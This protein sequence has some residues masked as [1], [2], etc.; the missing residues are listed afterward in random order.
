MQRV[1]RAATAA[2]RFR[3]S[4]K[5]EKGVEGGVGARLPTRRA[6]SQG[7]LAGPC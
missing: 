5:G 6:E 1:L 3:P 7:Q 4:E 2:P